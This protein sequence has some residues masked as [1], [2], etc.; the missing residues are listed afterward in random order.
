MYDPPL[1]DQTPAAG[2]HVATPDELTA[3]SEHSVIA[4][5]PPTAR[6][7]TLP[8]LTGPDPD[9]VVELNDPVAGRSMGARGA[10]RLVDV[11]TPATASTATSPG[12]D[13][14]GA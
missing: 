12:L 11:T 13:V 5:P 7:L 1:L 4:L 14:E 3:A 8:A 10:D 2:A 9:V 6:K